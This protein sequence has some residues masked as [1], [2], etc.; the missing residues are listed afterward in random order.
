MT[1]Q[2]VVVG[3]DGSVAAVRA[4][5]R[6]AEEAERRGAALHIVYAVP[7]RGAAAPILASAVS[8]TGTRHPGLPTVTAAAEGGAV[9]ALARASTAAALTV[10]GNRGFGV[11]AGTLA[12]SVSMR[13]AAQTHGPLLV[14]RG[15]H[16]CDNGHGVLLGLGSKADP[17]A[18]AYAFAEAERRGVCLSVLQS[19]AQKAV[20]PFPLAELQQ[21][22]PEV[23]TESCTVHN[24]PAHALLEA[25]R[26]AAVVVIGAYHRSTGLGRRTGSVVHTLLCRSHCPVAVVPNG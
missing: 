17:G 10:V 23:R 7:D 18:A 1:S 8:R 14:V 20:L 11:V 13:L 12:G 21:Q 4:L 24:D 9:Q 22:Y 2:H 25:G 16:R 19:R 5:D 3:V 26:E 6:A 15:D